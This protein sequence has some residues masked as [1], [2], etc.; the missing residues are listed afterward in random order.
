MGANAAY[1]PG[2]PALER[3]FCRIL[4]PEVGLAELEAGN[5]DVM[6]LPVAEAKA[7]GLANIMAA[8]ASPA[9]AWTS[10]RST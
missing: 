5:L 10:W 9:R 6:S 8:S 7:R 4:T 2:A 3:I 1:A